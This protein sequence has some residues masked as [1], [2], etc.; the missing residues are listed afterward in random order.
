MIT[1]PIVIVTLMGLN[2]QEFL[3]LLSVVASSLNEFSGPPKHFYTLLTDVH[4]RKRSLCV[5]DF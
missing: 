1:D 4:F 2:N 3:L 5:G